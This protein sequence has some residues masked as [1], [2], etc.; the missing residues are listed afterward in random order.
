VP[1]LVVALF[2]HHLEMGEFDAHLLV[3]THRIVAWIVPSL[4]DGGSSDAHLVEEVDPLLSHL[5]V[6]PTIYRTGQRERVSVH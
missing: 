2:E 5:G 1:R 6:R 4:D 3:G